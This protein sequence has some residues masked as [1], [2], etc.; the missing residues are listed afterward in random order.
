MTR[1]DQFCV[2]DLKRST[3]HSPVATPERRGH[4]N[5]DFSDDERALQES[6]RR[7]LAAR[8]D[9]KLVRRALDGE[10]SLRRDLWQELGQQ[11]WLSAALPEAYGGQG[12]GYV[13]QC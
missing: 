4:M 9:R 3:P 10:T 5:F 12:L 11:G 6:L 2:V 8:C 7:W 13:A 1:R